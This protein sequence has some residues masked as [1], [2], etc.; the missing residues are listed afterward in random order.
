MLGVYDDTNNL[1]KSQVKNALAV[2]GM[3][4]AE[5]EL[6]VAKLSSAEA[7]GMENSSLKLYNVT[8]LK[9][10][11]QSSNLSAEK[12]AEIIARLENKGTIEAENASLKTQLLLMAK[13]PMTWVSLAVTGLLSLISVISSTTKSAEELHEEAGQIKEDFESVSEKTTQNLKTLQ[14]KNGQGQSLTEEFSELCNGVDEYGN[15]ISLTNEQYERYKEICDTIVNI[16]PD[17]AE[18]YKSNTEAIGN[19]ANVLEDLIR[20]QEIQAKNAAKNATS[21]DNWDTLVDDAT[22]QYKSA[23]EKIDEAIRISAGDINYEGTSPIKHSIGAFDLLDFL[24][25]QGFD[26]YGGKLSDLLIDN[27]DKL[28]SNF[29]HYNN[30]WNDY[31]TSQISSGNWSSAYKNKFKEYFKKIIDGYGE[32]ENNLETAEE[33]MRNTFKTV[34]QSTDEYYDDIDASSRK[35]ITKWID[36]SDDFKVSSDDDDAINAAKDKIKK[37]IDK[38]ANTDYSAEFE[39]KTLFGQD[40]IKK[41]FS[42]DTSKLNLT[43]YEKQAKELL[44]HIYRM[45]NP[46]DKNVTD[47]DVINFGLNIGIDLDHDSEK[48]LDNQL[49]KVSNTLYKRLQEGTFSIPASIDVDKSSV[50]GIK[51]WLSSLS[52]DDINN[53]L[54][55][56]ANTYDSWYELENAIN[57][58]NNSVASI[59]AAEKRC[60]CDR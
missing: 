15:R 58:G 53:L 14:A 38:L 46:K 52:V 37:I 47:D 36:N 18:G 59:T 31:V 32:V 5:E 26:H 16:N 20:L 30:E 1:T 10:I 27:Y 19:N 44:N 7:T 55:I 50:D 6:I 3:T 12:Q 22:A 9:E 48:N 29:D 49:S 51:E 2:E 39:G 56:D 11:I 57:K 42:L 54:A 41:L 43:Q 35:F 21:G 8:K 45:L 24:E 34:A 4:D 25:E 13:N 17:I 60:K 28:K 33:G 40:F 23:K